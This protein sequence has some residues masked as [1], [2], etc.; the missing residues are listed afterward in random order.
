MSERWIQSSMK[1]LNQIS[2]LEKVKDKDRLEYV[3]SIRFMIGALNRSLIGWIQWV[4]NPDVMSKFTEEELKSIDKKLSEFVSSFIK[5]DIEVTKIG[6]E[7]GLGAR[8]RVARV[9]GG[10]ESLYV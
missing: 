6:A 3:R 4:N 8:R 10:E 1:I 7:K 2:E 5:Y 9:R